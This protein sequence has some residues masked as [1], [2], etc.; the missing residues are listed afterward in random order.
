MLR[1]FDGVSLKFQY[2]WDDIAIKQDG[3]VIPSRI[4]A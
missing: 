1:T 3:Q 4:A 2:L